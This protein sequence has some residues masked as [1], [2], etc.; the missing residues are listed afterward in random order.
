M[1]RD[2]QPFLLRL[3]KK[4]GRIFTIYV[5]GERMS[6]LSDPIFGNRQAWRNTDCLSLGH[7]IQYISPSLFGYSKHFAADIEFQ[8]KLNEKILSVLN[9]T[10]LIADVTQSL[11]ATYLSLID[12]GSV[13]TKFMDGDVIDLYQYSRHNMYYSSARALF[14]PEFPIDKIFLPYTRFEDGIVK[15]LKRYPRFLNSDGYNAQQKVLAELGSF[16]MDFS[17]VS[18]SSVLVRALYDI[19]MASIYKSP[20]DLAGYFFAII[21]ASKSNSVPAAF[22]LLANIVADAAL[23]AEIE[24]I[25]ASNYDPET[26]DFDWNKLLKNPVIVSC[27]KETV[28][29]NVNVISGRKVMKD[30]TIKVAS[31]SEEEAKNVTLRAGSLLLMPL[32]M[33]HWNKE[34]Y[35]DPMKW[36]GKRFLADNKGIHN[37]DKWRAAYAPWGGG[38]HM[39]PGRHLALLEAVIQLVYTLA[40]FDIE[41]IEDL[42][43]PIV[44]DRYGAGVFKP[45]RGYRVKFTR[46]KT[47]LPSAVKS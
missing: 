13:Y 27:F 16:F 37:A 1:A 18:K 33:L 20:A 40:H 9:S 30:Y 14:G 46:R 47:V 8:E 2:P 21:F 41:P 29:L 45:E 44:G 11:K 36:I 22:W 5:A 6:I 38:A 4:Y 17:R 42:P 3:Q 23:K 25:I 26:D 32:N 10:P 24:G 31:D 15:F 43:A 12:D 34:S 7:F 28:R 35:P 39:C 19:F